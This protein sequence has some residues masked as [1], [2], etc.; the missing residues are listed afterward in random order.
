MFKKLTRLLLI[1]V[2]TLAASQTFA[3]TLNVSLGPDIINNH[4]KIIFAYDLYTD[5]KGSSFTQFKSSVDL[6]PENAAKYFDSMKP[7]FAK[8][9]PMIAP[10]KTRSTLTFGYIKADGT[11]V[12]P[13]TCKK[14]KAKNVVNVVFSES[15]CIVNY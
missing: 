4:D 6:L 13:G 12:Y 11:T 10:N 8:I 3:M 2:L 9:T 15:G 5:V 1:A 14:F 7:Y